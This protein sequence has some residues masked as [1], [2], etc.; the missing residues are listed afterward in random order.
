[1]IR[2]QLLISMRIWIRLSTF[3]RIWILLPSRVIE[4]AATGLQTL[5]GSILSLHASIGRVYGPPRLHCEPLKL[6]NVSFVQMRIRII[7]WSWIQ[8]R[9]FLLFYVTYASWLWRTDTTLYSIQAELLCCSLWAPEPPF[10]SVRVVARSRKLKNV[11]KRKKKKV[12]F[13]D[14]L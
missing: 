1:M 8:I 6:L 12:Q 9:I 2:I 11:H 13:P 3:M 14:V 4:S 7:M 10:L 5:Q